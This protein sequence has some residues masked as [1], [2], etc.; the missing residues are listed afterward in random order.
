M[1]EIESDP[2]LLQEVSSKLRIHV[3]D[4]LKVIQEDFVEV[5]VG[6]RPHTVIGLAY[7]GTAVR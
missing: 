4:F 3:Q 1:S 7:G 5:A 6:E 2:E